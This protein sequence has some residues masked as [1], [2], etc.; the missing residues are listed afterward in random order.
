VPV[1]FMFTSYIKMT[2]ESEEDKYTFLYML[3]YEDN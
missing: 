1:I 2:G 3:R